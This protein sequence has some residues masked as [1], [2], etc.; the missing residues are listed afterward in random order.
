MV[1]KSKRP[2]GEGQNSKNRRAGAEK[3]IRD[4]ES[5]LDK[6]KGRPGFRQETRQDDNR[7]YRA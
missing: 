3:K 6:M 1:E 5:E 2:G 7:R 4:Q